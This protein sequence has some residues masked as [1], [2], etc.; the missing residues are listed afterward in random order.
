M[1]E[2]EIRERIEALRLALLSKPNYCLEIDSHHACGNPIPIEAVSGYKEGRNEFGGYAIIETLVSDGMDSV[3]LESAI[4][5]IFDGSSL[6]EVIFFDLETT[7]FCCCPLFLA[8]TLKFKGGGWKV[9]QLLARD[10]SEEAALIRAIE[11]N[12]R[13]FNHFVTFNGKSFDI[14]YIRERAKYHRLN[15]SPPLNHFDLLHHARRK[16]KSRLPNCRLRTLEY[17]VLGKRYSGGIDSWEVPCIY[18]RFVH[19]NDARRLIDVL[20]HNL[21]DIVS[22]AE[23]LAYLTEG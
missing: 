11:D 21:L 13:G 18:H 16:W 6:D 4:K 5:K 12:I 23:L 9:E 3:R 2:N 14:P 8:G 22:T 7:G 15:F 20:R 1:F 17:Y 10:Y 19:T